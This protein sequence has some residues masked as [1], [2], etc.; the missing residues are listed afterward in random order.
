MAAGGGGESS[1]QPE[2]E[3]EGERAME[4]DYSETMNHGGYRG[5]MYVENIS[6][7]NVGCRIECV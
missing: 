5:K 6:G 7:A 4:T 2:R 3:R 1:R